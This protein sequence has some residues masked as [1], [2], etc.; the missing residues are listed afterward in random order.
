[1]AKK[2][3]LILGALVLLLI[4]IAVVA[5][6]LLG[7]DETINEGSL[8]IVSET[9]AQSVETMVITREDSQV[10]LVKQ[11]G[12]WHYQDDMEA[13]VDQ[14]LT[15]SAL[16]YM[17]YV[18][19]D[20]IARQSVD[21]LTSYGLD[22]AAM[23]LQLWLKDGTEYVYN[24]GIS[25]S[26]KT[27]M[28]FQLEGDP[29]L[30]VFD[31]QKYNQ[32]VAALENL[33]D[34]SLNINAKSL[35]AFSLMRIGGERVQMDFS[36]IPEEQRIGT[37]EWL[38][39]APIN[40][41]ANPDAVQLVEVLFS[42]ARLAGFASDTL[43]P[44]HGINENSAFLSMKD[45]QGREVKLMFG[46]RTEEGAYY[47]TVSDRDGVYTAYSGMEELLNMDTMDA[48]LPTVFP[49]GNN[50][51]NFQLTVGS[52]DYELVKETGG[53]CLNGTMITQQDAADIAKY[54]TS[55]T[56]DGLALD[57]NISSKQAQFVLENNSD[58]KIDFSVYNK[59]YLA[60]SMQ[61]TPYAYIKTER[62]VLLVDILDGI[63]GSN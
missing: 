7:E 23:S 45:S 29:N 47:C 25:T 36:I 16:T 55:V 21:D 56:A 40:A 39:H 62:L 37:E 13:P 35:T 41:I 54:M 22:P 43:L 52:M 51:P 12:L 15:E 2:R 44:V 4:V 8:I 38:I 49:V 42:P 59:D 27:G 9:D 20:K 61:D 53:Y 26:D 60:M 5:V 28:F 14:L 19:A 6:V 3:L 30:Y 32:V 24:F 31:I 1:M 11:N 46:N 10:S 63:I 57:A 33:K 48:I 17:S 18:Y 58:I 34:L 50:L